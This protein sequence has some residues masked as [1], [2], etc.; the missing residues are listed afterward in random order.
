MTGNT[1][2]R[3]YTQGETNRWGRVREDMNEGWR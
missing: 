2:S 1:V 3:A